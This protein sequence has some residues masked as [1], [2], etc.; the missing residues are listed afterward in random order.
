MK[1]REVKTTDGGTVT[2]WIPENP[3]DVEHLKLRW[4]MGDMELPRGE[5]RRRGR[6]KPLQQ[7]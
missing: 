6:K 2:E 5:K 7:V 4:I 3:G 1:Q